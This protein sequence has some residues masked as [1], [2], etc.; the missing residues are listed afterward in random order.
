VEVRHPVRIT[1]TYTQTL[2]GT[3]VEVL[4]LLCPVR[5]VEWVPGW[6]PRLV[7]SASGV[8]EPDCV[9]TTPDAAAGPEAEAI[10]T[11]LAQDPAAGTVEML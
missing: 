10:W 11:V 2:D 5:E 4:P 7:L 3:P 6:A 1:H 9:F 8:A